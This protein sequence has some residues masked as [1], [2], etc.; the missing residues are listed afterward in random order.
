VTPD[1][2]A[3]AL[4]APYVTS[5]DSPV[6]ALRDLPEEVVAVLFAYYSR[7][8][9]DLRSSLLRL[10][11]EQ[12]LDLAGSAA[13]ALQENQSLGQARRKAQEFHEKWVVG[14]GHASVAEHAVAHLAIED[15][16]IIAS[17]VIE[18]A[19]LASYTEKSTRYVPFSRAFYTAPELSD[20]TRYL[21]AIHRLFDHYEELLPIV[22]EA[23][24]ATA[25]RAQFKTERGFLNSCTA[26]ACDALRYLLPAAT[27]TNL[28]L[29]ANARTLEHLVSKMLSHPLG[30]VREIGSRIKEHASR[31]I[32]T[33]IKYARPSEYLRETPP[34]LTSLAAELLAVAC[35]DRTGG[36][37]APVRLVASPTDPE[38]RLA[39]AILSEFCGESY[40][41]IQQALTNQG[42]AAVQRVIEAYLSGR[43]TYGDP[44]HGYTDPPLRSLEHLYFTFEIVVDYGAYRDIQ[45]HRMA[46]Q[47]TQPLGCELGYDVPELLVRCGFQQ[48]FE[49]AME[50]AADAWA[51]LRRGPL[52]EL[53]QYVVPL[54]YR[55]RALI[56][57]NLRELHHFIG[58][59]SARQGH[60]SYRR[61]AQQVYHE[62]ERAHPF[63][64]RFIRVDL[65]DYEMARPG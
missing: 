47:T 22:T 64:A 56:T 55:K 39:A 35:A 9:E 28:G 61:I 29:T 42:P 23:I 40:N 44:V 46:T 19:R 51:A 20:G 57:W 14:Y 16:S 43:R 59:R 65:Q 27:L 24:R 8:R 45:R 5:L 41:A 21:E 34:A 52:P 30:E 63:L 58:L 54:A 13:T 11:R 37:A 48:R 32:P 31:V 49:S 1:P 10:I 26:Q 50:E 62:L 33:L 2:A 36:E 18:D 15:V 17:K 25:D 38:P 53:A 3:S 6:F 12:D 60:P 4:L 7:S